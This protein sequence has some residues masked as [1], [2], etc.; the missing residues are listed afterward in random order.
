MDIHHGW[1]WSSLASY[2]TMEFLVDKIV[3]DKCTQFDSQTDLQTN[4]Y[5]NCQSRPKQL[6]QQVIIHGQIRTVIKSSDL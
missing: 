4:L 1:K 3:H 6:S 5:N 2:V